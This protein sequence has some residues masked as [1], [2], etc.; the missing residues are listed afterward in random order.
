MLVLSWRFKLDKLTRNVSSFSHNDEQQHTACSPHIC[1][2]EI[3][4]HDRI[5]HRHNKQF[6]QTEHIIL[7]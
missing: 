6:N 7:K 3:T 5:L 1:S 4:V 2:V